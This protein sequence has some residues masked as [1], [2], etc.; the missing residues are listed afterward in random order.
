VK[1]TIFILFSSLAISSLPLFTSL[2]GVDA[3]STVD[4]TFVAKV[5]Q[6]GMYEVEA[7]KVAEQRATAQDVMDIAA[8]DVHDHTLVNRELIKIAAAQGINLPSQLN[9]TF[10]QRLAHLKHVSNTEFNAAYISDMAQIHD[11]DEKLFAQEA[12]DG[13]G[14]LKVFAAKTDLIVKRHIGTIHGTDEK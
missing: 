12:L 2:Q 13:T 10:E 9:A 8:M 4:S 3:A 14:D 7:S 5:S 6:G 11:M 1:A